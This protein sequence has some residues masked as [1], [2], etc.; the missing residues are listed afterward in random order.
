MTHSLMNEV[1]R[2]SPAVNDKSE[3]AIARVSRLRAA[4]FENG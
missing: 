4:R 2:T 3:F 1:A